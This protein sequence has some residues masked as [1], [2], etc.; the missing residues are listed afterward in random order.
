M[1]RQ[2]HV[3]I[4]TAG[5]NIHAAYTAAIRDLAD[6]THTYVFADTELYTNSARDDERTKAYKTAARDAAN[7]V[8]SVSLSLKIPAS[9]IYI[10]PPASGSVIKAILKIKKEHPDARYSFNLSAGSKDLSM[11]LFTISLW[12]EG[13][14]YYAFSE[15]KGDAA[16]VKMA[17]PKNPARDMWANPNYMKILSFLGHT[18]GEKEA[19]PRVLPRQY[20]FTQ[21]ESFYVPVR[22]KGVKTVTSPTKTDLFTGKRAIIPV[23]SQ[24]TLTNLLSAM[25]AYGLIR[26]AAGPGGNR[27]EKC[28]AITPV[29]ELALKFS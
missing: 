29:G 19:T 12:L 1:A 4:I 20:I 24:G 10:D 8:K 2:E 23:L 11:A 7:K 5:E 13:D 3:H 28:Y 21:L 25:T 6:I 27:K 9:L 18:P 14:A 16:P 26:E 22:K 17:I 15:R